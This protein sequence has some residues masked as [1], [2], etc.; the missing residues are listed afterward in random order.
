[1]ILIL[2]ILT[3]MRPVRF[4][5]GASLSYNVYSQKIFFKDDLNIKFKTTSSDGGLAQI[6]THDPNQFI[7]LMIKNK[8]RFR[9]LML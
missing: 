7:K 4:N 3:E 8:V 6:Q 5:P 9:S 1:M 2:L